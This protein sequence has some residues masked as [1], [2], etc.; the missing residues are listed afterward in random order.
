MDFLC[1]VFRSSAW[2]SSSVAIGPWRFHAC[3]NVI[4]A[5]AVYSISFVFD[6]SITKISATTFRPSRDRRRPPVAREY[7]RRCSS[8]NGNNLDTLAPNSTPGH[9]RLSLWHVGE[10]TGLRCALSEDQ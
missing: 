5:R 3:E 10:E 6:R 9:G 2:I 8:S 1:P 4:G 7:C